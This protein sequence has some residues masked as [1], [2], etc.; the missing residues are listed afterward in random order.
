VKCLIIKS[1]HVLVV[2]ALCLAAFVV[3]KCVPGV[4]AA[5]VVYAGGGVSVLLFPG[6]V[7]L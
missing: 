4:V 2:A 1:G 6:G 5:L 7:F 3:K